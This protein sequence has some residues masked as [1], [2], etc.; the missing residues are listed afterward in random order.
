MMEIED[1]L[2]ASESR[3]RR[4]FESAQYGILMLDADSGEIVDVNPFMVSLLGYSRSEFLG[5][6]LWQI[7]AVKDVAASKAAFRE[8]QDKDYIRYDD[9]PLKTAEGR[10]IAVEFVSNIYLVDGKKAIQCNVHEITQRKLAEE[11][12]RQSERL[13]RNLVD[14]LPHRI[15]VKDL[16]SVIQFCNASYAR[17]VGMTPEMV[18]GKDA[19]AFYS[20]ELA[21]AYNADDHEVMSRGTMKDVEEPYGA[22]GEG[23]WVH[24]VKVPYR[25]EQGAVIGLLVVFEDITEAKR[26]EEQLRQSQKLEGIGQLAGG[27]AHDF[28]NLLTVI[29]GYCDLVARRLRPNDPI[30]AEVEEIR[31][32]GVRATELTRHLLAFSRKQVLEVQAL[33]LNS[34]V[35]DVH[36]ML[37]R[38]IGE[39]IDLQTVLAPDLGRIMADP[40]QIEQVIMNLAVNAR[41]AM[42][43]G[44]K[45]TLETANVDLG[46][47]YAGRHLAVIPGP[48]V[49][50]A[51]TDNGSGM[52]S[53]IR[54]R[55]F[56]PFFTTKELGKGTGLG[57]S[58]VYGIVKQ[59]S[60]NVWCYSEP[61]H[62]TTFK[63]Y[64]PRVEE[65][66]E[67]VTV[68]RRDPLVRG[69]ETVLVAEDEEMVR[70]LIVEM[71]GLDGYEVIATRNGAEALEAFKSHRGPIDLLITDV[72]MPGIG[73][74][75]LMQN[76][77]QIRPG[78][79]VLFMSGYTGDAVLRHGMLEAGTAFLQKPFTRDALNRRVREVLDS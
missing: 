33:D 16:N 72:I 12:L 44:G 29:L 56:E 27:V 7:G 1:A 68:A 54:G 15:L 24:T 60:G 13:N 22:A 50:L 41:D 36:R 19:F 43:A 51:V 6:K 9:L 46:E 17:D 23:R 18:I 4:L 78:M 79:K 3:Y 65:E 2:R 32:C 76:L 67:P 70:K 55:I 34:L 40:G 8:L 49:M 30:T 77:V 21:R 10:E 69:S 48:Y 42:P 74:N 26:L 37:Q 14:H 28:N 45:L 31:K 53:A 39:N 73:G 66:A 62:G 20:P 52:K 47:E 59:S 75:E 58:T 38:V 61:D 57:L 25:D 35:S 71:L 5:K 11:S 63:I 64:L